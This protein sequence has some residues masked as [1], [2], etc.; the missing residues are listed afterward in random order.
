MCTGM[1]VLALAGTGLSAVG[2]IQ[3]AN[4][5]SA[6]LEREAQL[7]Q[8]EAT[9]EKERLA[10]E[11]ERTEGLQRVAAAK[12]GAGASGSILETMQGSAEQAEL[13]ALN[14]QFGADAGSQARLFEAKQ[15]KNA[16][17]VGAGST[18]LTGAS[19]GGLF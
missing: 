17:F 2:Q 11:Q 1:E 18:L 12:S 7:A 3:S 14:I 19:K 10:E 6:T 13:E 15:V 8:Q 16:G 9:F 5:Q 4:A